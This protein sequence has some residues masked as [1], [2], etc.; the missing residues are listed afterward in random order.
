MI[1]AVGDIHGCLDPLRR[2]LDVIAAD[3]GERGLARPRVVFL[4]DYVDRGPDSKGVLDLLTGGEVE[5]R[6]D[7]V[8]LLG[9]H[10]LALRNIL[11]GSSPSVEWMEEQGGWQTLRSYGDFRARRPDLSAKRFRAAVPE[12]H[13]R[14]LDGL[15]PSWRDGDVLFSHAGFSPDFPADA[16]PFGALVCGDPRML[17]RDKDAEEL[18]RRL[19]VRVVHGHW[20]TR[21]VLVLPHRVSVDTGAGYASG[22][23]SAVAISG[24]DV[25]R[26]P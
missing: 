3:A 25:R 24:E 17:G 22:K 14:F 20:T 15:V 26:L 12:A 21:E 19:G 2:L 5:Q 9:N 7:P 18:R 4:G 6:F 10:D 23:L 1:Y 11:Q 8:F 13:R 16:Q